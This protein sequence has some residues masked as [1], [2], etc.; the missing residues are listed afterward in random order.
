MNAA[1]FSFAPFAYIVYRGAKR[2]GLLWLMSRDVTAVKRRKF[3]FCDFHG[4]IIF[5][6][7]SGLRFYIARNSGQHIQ[8]C[9][10]Y[11]NGRKSYPN[12]M[13]SHTKPG[14][15]YL[16]FLTRQKIFQ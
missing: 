9:T 12:C 11:L 15:Q 2:I 3:V 14:I 8:I 1:F 7:K 6:K 10:D 4:Y 5:A 13:I 16:T